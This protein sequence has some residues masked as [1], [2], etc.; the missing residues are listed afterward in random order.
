VGE[1]RV[2]MGEETRVRR[3]RSHEYIYTW[4]AYPHVQHEQKF[5]FYRLLAGLYLLKLDLGS[6]PLHIK[7][8]LIYYICKNSAV[9]ATHIT[10][11]ILL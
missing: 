10:E 4:V 11:L 8:F 5:L 3:G 6:L 1:R 7:K 9:A 2:W